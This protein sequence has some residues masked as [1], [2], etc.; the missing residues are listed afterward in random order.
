MGEAR[1][2]VN[3]K[4]RSYQTQLVESCADGEQYILFKRIFRL[5]TPLLYPNDPHTEHIKMCDQALWDSGKVGEKW[6][7][8]SSQY[9]R[10]IVVDNW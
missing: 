6:V 1:A 2:G 9:L 7:K 10:E 5:D 4:S 3:N 8:W